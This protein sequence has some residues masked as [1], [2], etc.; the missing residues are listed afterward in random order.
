MPRSASPLLAALSLFAA[1]IAV[2]PTSGE[3]QSARGEAAWTFLAGDEDLRVYYRPAS[4]APSGSRRGWA[5]YENASGRFR[6]EVILFE[7]DCAEQRMRSLQAIGYAR[8]NMSSNPT[9]RSVY[10]G[11]VYVLPGTYNATLFGIWC[12]SNDIFGLPPERAVP[13]AGGR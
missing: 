5:R 8:P 12:D 11:W 9:F 13:P 3:T 1:A 7:V 2:L 4:D 10:N 6:S